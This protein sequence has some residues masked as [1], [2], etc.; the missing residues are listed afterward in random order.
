MSHDFWA[1]R[2]DRLE[3]R[4]RQHATGPRETTP[5]N[6]SL[7]DLSP[8]PEKRVAQGLHIGRDSIPLKRRRSL[9]LC[10]ALSDRSP[11]NKTCTF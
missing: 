5:G 7:A 4:I 10:G 2:V 3:S 6:L 8:T 9:T 11:E 1:V